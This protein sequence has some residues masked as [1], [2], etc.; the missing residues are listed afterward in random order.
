[1]PTRSILCCSTERCRRRC[2]FDHHGDERNQ[3]REPDH[4]QSKT[5][6]RCRLPC[7]NFFAVRHTEIT[8]MAHSRRD[9]LR[10]SACALGRY[11]TGIK[12][13]KFWQS[14][15]HLL[16][17]PRSDYKALVC[18]FLN[19]GNDG[20]NMFLDLNQYNAVRN[21]KL[22][23][24]AA[25]LAIPQANFLPVSAGKRW[26]YG[27]HPNMPEVQ[28]SSIRAN[29]RCFATTARWLSRLTKTHVPK[30]NGKKPLQLFSHSDQVG[31]FQTAIANR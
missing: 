29:W 11:G 5:G 18:V 24:S 31:L 28:T 20:N 3:R 26:I 6:S 1:M 27:F 15:T 13:R 12:H 2:E 16:P 17:R 7:G 9:F 23:R 25:G 30:R 8:I 19:G 22:R 10:T 21:F 4:T 14:F